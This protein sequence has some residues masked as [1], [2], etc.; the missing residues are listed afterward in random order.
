MKVVCFVWNLRDEY[1]M[2]VNDA[3]TLRAVAVLPLPV[4]KKIII[5]FVLYFYCLSTIAAVR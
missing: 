5:A 4:D 1:F 3:R 2:N